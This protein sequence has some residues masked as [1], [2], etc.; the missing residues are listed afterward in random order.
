MHRIEGASRRT[1]ARYLAGR[2]TRKEAA[3]L[4]SMSVDGLRRLCHRFRAAGDRAFVH[5]L[6]GKPSNRRRTPLGGP[7]PTEALE[8]AD[9]DMRR[10]DKEEQAVGALLIRLFEEAESVYLQNQGDSLYLDL[11]TLSGERRRAVRVSL[12][13]VLQAILGDEEKH[14]CAGCGDPKAR[15]AFGTT[16]RG[17]R[18]NRCRTCENE[19]TAEIRRKKRREG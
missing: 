6:A 18:V 1:L 13:Y 4:L 3:R 7:L 2:L 15:S 10:L 9:P 5:G 17:S 8:D 12:L 11:V 14:V 19:R 16:R